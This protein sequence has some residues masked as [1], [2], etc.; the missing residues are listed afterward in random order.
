MLDDFEPFCQLWTTAADWKAHQQAW[1]HGPLSAVDPE[2]LEKDLAA[3]GKALTKLGKVRGG[4]HACAN[5]LDWCWNKHAPDD[6][7]ASCNCPGVAPCRPSAAPPRPAPQAFTARS[8]DKMAANCEELKARVEAF[9]ELAPL[10]AALRAPGMRPRHWEQLSAQVGGALRAAPPSV[11]GPV[12][13]ASGPAAGSNARPHTATLALPPAQVGQPVVLDSGLTLAQAV[14]RGL[15]AHL[16]A[17]TAVAET[18]AKEWAIEQVG[19]GG[20]GM[21]GGERGGAGSATA[22]L[23]TRCVNSIP[24][25]RPAAPLAPGHRQA[26]RG[27]GRRR[28]RRRLLPRLGN[29]CHQGGGASSACRLEP[30]LIHPALQLRRCTPGAILA[31]RTAPARCPAP[32]QPRTAPPPPPRPQVD[33]ALMQQLD[34]NLVMLQSMGFSPH[35][36]PFEERLAKWE[37]QLRLVRAGGCGRV[38]SD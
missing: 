30:Q 19:G 16:P 37:M 33:E 29:V 24:E 22:G 18:A 3:A 38:R 15:M 23:H 26:D 36:K 9:K 6:A 4:R 7:A 34:D 17:A 1:Q 12:V 11:C 20:R 25:P 21:G 5:A 32:L 2:A 28:G 31:A 13:Q 27:L 10:A 35:K 14:E 8:L